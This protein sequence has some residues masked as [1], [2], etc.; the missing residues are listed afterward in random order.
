MIEY[1]YMYLYGRIGIYN[2]YNSVL[3]I[4]SFA[5][6]GYMMHGKGRI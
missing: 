6:A 5:N 4:Y 3:E 1:G 2:M